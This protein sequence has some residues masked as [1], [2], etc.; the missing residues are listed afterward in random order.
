MPWSASGA[1]WKSPRWLDLDP[2]LRAIAEGMGNAPSNMWRQL[3]EVQAR[4]GD[5]ALD[6]AEFKET[7]H[8]R[9]EGG[10]FTGKGKGVAAKAP[11]PPAHNDIAPEAIDKY[12]Q[13]IADAPVNEGIAAAEE[14]WRGGVADFGDP[15]AATQVQG[16]EGYFDYR[17][18]LEDAAR[19]HLGERFNVYRLMR[20]EQ[21]KAWKN[22]EDMPPMATS[23]SPSFAEKFKQ[24]AGFKDGKNLVVV[25]I[26]A[27]PNSLV[28]RGSEA[29]HEL[30]IDPNELDASTVEQVSAAATHAGQ[31][32]ETQKFGTKGGKAPATL[33]GV[34]MAKWADPPTNADGWRD[35]A[36]EDDFE[37]PPAPQP[38]PG[39]K[40]G[41]GV[42]IRE[43]DGRIWIVHPANAYGGYKATFP[44]GTVDKGYSL[45]ATALKEAMEESGLKVKLTGYAGDVDRD[46]SVGRYYYAERTGGT[47]D[48]HGWESEA[49]SLAKPEDLKSILN[50][51]T[52]RKMV[53]DFITSPA[54]AA[55]KSTGPGSIGPKLSM[56]G[57]KRVGPQM[58]SNPGGVYQ[59]P[60]GQKYY[61]KKQKSDDHARNELL[62]AALFQKAGG[63]T[64]QYHPIADDDD[65]DK[66]NTATRMQELAKDNIDQLDA[67]ERKAAQQDFALHAWLANWDAAGL[68]GDNIGVD[69]HGNV[70]PLDFGG[71]LLYRAQGSPKGGAFNDKASEWD[72]LRDPGMNPD[73]AD[74]YGDMTD[75]DLRRSAERLQGISDGD[76]RDLV[77]QW[78][79][80]N[81][82]GLAER[83]IARKKNILAN[84]GLAQDAGWDS[85]EW[86]EEQH[87]RKQSGQFTKKG[88]GET[89]AEREHAEGE[90]GGSR[91]EHGSSLWPWLA[92]MFRVFA[93]HLARSTGV[94]S[95]SGAGSRIRFGLSHKGWLKGSS[96]APLAPRAIPAPAR[97]WP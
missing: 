81:A 32:P 71:S 85:P 16:M 86:Q 41:A 3:Y 1:S 19:E 82:K 68:G 29:E 6:D 77:A 24:F 88:T 65:P 38:P 44:K 40:L 2:D 76:I 21:L 10:K 36:A 30:V 54:K 87:P 25:R 50:R 18:H 72:T 56:T 7:E 27:T 34:P 47:P 90:V 37:E 28:M 92:L 31:V 12:Q 66:L 15:E 83:L 23:M 17:S 53:D 80:R 60:D 84:V 55:V 74:L 93:E 51:S 43:P 5:E 35:L 59:A 63:R 39:K 96:R 95:G 8:P 48:D 14:N 49:V 9:D 52:D 11:K 22:G 69:E 94:V 64:F 20:P 78:G 26:P 70:I 58:G 46:T 61:F 67:E 91:P 57:W 4:R 62:A 75:A 33:N 13:A 89:R 73:S 97:H 45:R 79:P 42:I